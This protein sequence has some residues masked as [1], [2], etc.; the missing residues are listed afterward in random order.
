MSRK[1]AFSRA[2]PTTQWAGEAPGW[3][4]FSRPETG[5][6]R[7]DRTDFPPG[8][9]WHFL[10]RL[11]PGTSRLCLSL[12]CHAPNIVCFFFKKNVFLKFLAAPDGIW[13]LSSQ[14]REQISTSC[15]GISLNQP[16]NHQCVLFFQGEFT[17]AH[18]IHSRPDAN[19]TPSAAPAVS[20]SRAPHLEPHTCVPCPIQAEFLILI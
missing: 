16:P 5:W 4:E 10:G 11:S 2:S 9:E 7:R 20:P 14:T 13:D 3:G 18:E 6:I 8:Y 1:G 15:S 17:F 19:D 12:R